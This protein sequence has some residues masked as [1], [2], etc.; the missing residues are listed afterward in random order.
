MLFIYVR[1]E[2][3]YAG[4]NFDAIQYVSTILV[5]Y[6]YFIR[7]RYP[8]NVLVKNDKITNR[9]IYLPD[10]GT[11]GSVGAGISISDKER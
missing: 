9:S 1:F 4:Y 2:K 10:F 5:G 3:F 7:T 8:Q 11:S 6:H